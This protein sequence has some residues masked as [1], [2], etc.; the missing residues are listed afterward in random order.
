MAI[1]FPNFL[2]AQLSK[3]DYSG[4]ADIVSNYYAGKNMPK[5][6]LIKQIEAEFA[7]PNAE[8]NLANAKITGQHNKALTAHTLLQVQQLKQQLAE[9]AAM[10][11]AIK[12]AIAQGGGVSTGA[13]GQPNLTNS[14]AMRNA[15]APNQGEGEVMPMP[16]S[17]DPTSNG[18]YRDQIDP[19]F[20]KFDQ[21]A[22]GLPNEAY[23]P[24]AQPQMPM[25]Q[26]GAMTPI[27]DR[28]AQI[29]PL[30]AQVMKPQQPAQP[31]PI[32]SEHIAP[33]GEQIKINGVA[34][35]QTHALLAQPKTT[36]ENETIVQKGEPSLY[37][38][39]A[40][41]DRSPEARPYL[42]KKGYKKSVKTSF[43]KKTGVTRIETT[44]P[45]GKIS[46]LTSQPLDTGKEGIPLTSSMITKNQN[47]IAGVDNALPIIQQ[48]LEKPD[49]VAGKIQQFPRSSGW[50]PG[51]GYVPGFGNLSNRYENMV[52]S[53][54]DS[55]IGAYGLNKSDKSTQMVHDQVLIGHNETDAAYKR[56]L[57]EL[58]K[59]LERRRDYSQKEVKRSNKISP[60]SSSSGSEE[61]DATSGLTDE[62]LEAIANG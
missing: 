43:D 57:R 6:A 2:S 11:A 23:R 36:E 54:V 55:L 45:S 20:R 27:N 7:R 53:V 30:L 35:E 52:N 12:K 25:P 40:L 61:S 42:E 59:D 58:V 5:D 14:P 49:T 24:G 22:S 32:T 62:Q 8:T 13:G 19:R 3:P 28:M 9:Q 26:R 38:I 47:V 4:I 10:E 56:R 60:I 16:Q 44:S 48:I 1:Q 21:M 39:D 18:Y 33:A 31:V 29:A 17:N 41:Y 34:P 46:V 15:L 50:L 37:G 51:M